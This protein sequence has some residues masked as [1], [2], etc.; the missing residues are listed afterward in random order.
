MDKKKVGIVSATLALVAG[1]AVTSIVWAFYTTPLQ[2]A[3]AG[4]VSR[5]KWEIKFSRLAT[6]S[7]DQTATLGNDDEG[8]TSTA[9]EVQKPTITSDTT[10]GTYSVNLKTPGDYASYE[11]DITNNGTFD[12]QIAAGWSLPTPDCDPAEN[13]TATSTDADNVCGNLQYTLVYTDEP[14]TENI[15]PAQNAAVAAGDILEAGETRTVLLKLYYKKTATVAQLPS[16]DIT[17][18]N[19]G[20]TITYNQ[21]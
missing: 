17:V 15:G 2:I 4:T 19:L 18:S 10:I 3:G 7:E 9:R 12:A 13:G 14:D 21:K 16:D 8:A 6:V 5:A 11:F 1:I 20:F